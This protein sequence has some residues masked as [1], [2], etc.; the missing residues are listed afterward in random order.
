MKRIRRL[1]YG[2]CIVLLIIFVSALVYPAPI[3]RMVFER[4]ENQTDIAITF[5]RVYFS[6]D[7]EKE[8]ADALRRGRMTFKGLNVKR[9]DH[10]VFNFNLTAETVQFAFLPFRYRHST[11]SGLRG[12][13][14]KTGERPM[15]HHTEP[16][17]NNDLM[18]TFRLRF[19]EDV[20]IDFIDRTLAKPFQMTIQIVTASMSQNEANTVSLFAPYVFSGFG[21]IDSANFVIAREGLP[22]DNFEQQAKITE[23]PIALFAPYAPVL[24]DVFAA[25]TMNMGIEDLSDATQKKIRLAI[26]LLPDCRIK[27][28]NE[29]LAPALQIAL[30]N[31]DSDVLPALLELQNR[32]VRLR[33]NSEAIRAELERVTEILDVLRVLAPRDVRER[34]DNFRARYDRAKTNYEEWNS[35]VESLVWELDG[36]KVRVIEETFQRFIETGDPIVMEVYETDGDWQFDAYG[37]LVHLIESNYRVLVLEFR[38]HLRE[39]L[40]AVDR[41]FMEI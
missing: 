29:I 31:L 32:V 41:L 24:D 13:V 25:G 3:F 10:P 12:I 33:N 21:Q 19:L 14:E 15:N 26:T 40:N 27:P 9:Q 20:E 28:A 37:M 34:Y 6:Y 7:I 18:Q 17:M 23:I 5:D 39:V 4:I 38:Q 35:R 30:Q 16:E 11:V 1:T 2:L 8:P 36:I 22:P